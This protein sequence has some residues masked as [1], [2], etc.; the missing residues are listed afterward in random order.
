MAAVAVICHSNIPILGYRAIPSRERVLRSEF[1]GYFFCVILR[2]NSWQFLAKNNGSSNAYTATSN[3][4]FYF[5]VATPALAPALSRFAGFFHS[6][7]FS[8]SCTSRE[9]N[10]V[11]SENKKNLQAD[12]W[13]IY[14]VNKHL[15]ID[16][17]VWRKFGSGNR[18]SLSKAGRILKEKQR[19]NGVATGTSSRSS[20]AA[21]SPISSRI[22]SPAPSIASTN[23][24]SDSDGGFIGRETRRRLVEWWSKEY[25]ASRMRLCIIGK[26]ISIPL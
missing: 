17:H 12:M 19:L 16:G 1:S 21:P 9:L 24:E 22:P 2:Y 13:R 5:T 23:S 4:N 25:C 11:D 26:G 6:P 15:S 7:L 14:Q 18:E 8:P 3:T 20:S 10:A